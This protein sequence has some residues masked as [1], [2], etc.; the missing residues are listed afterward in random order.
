MESADG[1]VLISYKVGLNEKDPTGFRA[2]RLPLDRVADL[3]RSAGQ[4][5]AVQFQGGYRCAKN[6]IPGSELIVLD[7]DAGV[8]LS[9][10]VEM[11]GQYIGIVATTR[12]HRKEKNGV[13]CDRFRVIL[14][15]RKP[16]KLEAVEFSK[17]MKEVIHHYGTDKAC[18]DMSRMYYGNPEAEVF[19]L[20]GYQL[21]DWEPFYQ[22]A[23]DKERQ[24]QQQ[25]RKPIQQASGDREA[26]QLDKAIQTFMQKEFVPGARNPTLF[27]VSRWL[28]DKGIDDVA[29]MVH[30]LNSKSGC[31]L[32]DDEVN[33]II[34]NALTT[35]H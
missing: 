19:F 16:V 4:Y 28:K 15:T 33:K 13:V 26:A 3:V 2:Y 8:T 22:S 9:N 17:M 10:A 14:P 7:Y 30:S 1:K 21:F 6:A 29:S 27:K 31:P 32:P 12:S 18:S 24:R 11:F 25:Y 34:R 5:S 23:L 35:K 20:D